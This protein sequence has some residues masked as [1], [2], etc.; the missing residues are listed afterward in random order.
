MVKAVSLHKD[1]QWGFLRKLR[2]YSPSEH[3]KAH[4]LQGQENGKGG[5]LE[6]R[7]IL[8]LPVMTSKFAKILMLHKVRNLY[9]IG[10]IRNR[11]NP[12]DPWSVAPGYA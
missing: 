9:F 4:F 3:K 2:I 10:K 6:I 12:F 5:S 1:Y 11:I 8:Y 7:A